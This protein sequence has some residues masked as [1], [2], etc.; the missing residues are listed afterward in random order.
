MKSSPPLPPQQPGFGS[1]L[2]EQFWS[3]LAAALL[4]FATSWLQ[5]Q[6]VQNDL[7]N[8][9]DRL[10]E[11][12]RDASAIDAKRADADLQNAREMERLAGAVKNVADRQQEMRDERQRR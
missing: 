8:K 4:G 10:E 2:R 7:R 12:Q 9:V 6:Y 5:S 1:K 11:K 3:L